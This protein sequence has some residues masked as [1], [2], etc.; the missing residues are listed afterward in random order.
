MLV[1]LIFAAFLGLMALLALAVA[2]IGDLVI[3]IIEFVKKNK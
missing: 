3:R 2:A 1:G